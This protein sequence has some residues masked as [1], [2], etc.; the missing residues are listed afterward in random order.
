MIEDSHFRTKTPS[1]DTEKSMRVMQMFN[2]ISGFSLE[3]ESNA[4][5]ENKWQPVQM[6]FV[7][8]LS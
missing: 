3:N 4:K 1:R 6:A 5:V 8:V 7:H 2:P